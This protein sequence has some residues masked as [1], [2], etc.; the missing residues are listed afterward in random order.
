MLEKR[1]LANS[2][3]GNTKKILGILMMNKIFHSGIFYAGYEHPGWLSPMMFLTILL[4]STMSEAKLDS[5]PDE[6]MGAVTAQAGIEIDIKDMVAKVDLSGKTTNA[7][8]TP[9]FYYDYTDD[10]SQDSVHLWMDDVA[11][12]DHGAAPGLLSLDWTK[13][14]LDISRINSQNAVT[15]N[16]FGHTGG[17]DISVGEIKMNNNYLGSMAIENLRLIQYVPVPQVDW[18]DGAHWEHNDPSGLGGEATGRDFPIAAYD[19][20]KPTAYVKIAGDKSGSG[21]SGEIAMG[22]GFDSVRY[23]SNGRQSGETSLEVSGF[24]T[25]IQIGDLS[26][27]KPLNYGIETDQSGRSYAVLETTWLSADLEIDHIRFSGRNMMGS[28]D[29]G[30][31]QLKG[32]ELEYLRVEFPGRGGTGA[33]FR[34]SGK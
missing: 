13:I 5:L 29:V 11:L 8:Y 1:R 34:N 19:P 23:Y 30:P 32:V 15:M 21:L 12:S 27:N 22:L 7:T 9:T 16:I 20:L 26:R 4:F 24:R 33:T 10:P 28:D 18:N 14:A 3:S 6:K 17:M 2:R 31:F 25:N